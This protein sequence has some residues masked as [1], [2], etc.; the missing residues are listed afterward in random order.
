[1]NDRKVLVSGASLAGPTLAYWLA[2]HGFE[3]TVVERAEKPRTG[4][5]PI[6]VR[7]PA[8]EVAAK[9]GILPEIT[10]ARTNTRGI[11]FVDGT[12]KRV[13]AVGADI[14]AE[15][16]GHDIE[17]EREDLVN[18]LFG[19]AKNDVEYV[20]EE[21]IK[22]LDQDD[23]GVDVTFAQGG[24]RRFDF[25]V[26][27]DGLHSAVRRLAFGEE[28]RFVRHLG[29]YVGIVD[30]DPR[31]ARTD[32]GVM[33]N[34]P[35]KLAGVYSFHGKAAAVFM[36]RSPELSYDYR[37]LDEQKK[38]LTGVFEN[39]SWQVPG[40]LDALATADDFYF[41]SVSQVRMTPWSQGRVSLVGDAG[42]CPALLSGMGTSLAMVGASVLANELAESPDDHARA[43]ARYHE[44]HRPLVDKAQAS[45]ARG[46]GLLIPAT[47][48]AIWR[49]NQLAKVFPLVSAARRVLKPAKSVRG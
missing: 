44:L 3:V 15:Q 12:G 38:L 40:L 30:V 10:A 16:A 20:F 25:V 13:A 41:D 23:G 5:S 31:F 11:E 34:S 29:M 48:G 32:W 49:R 18:I 19:A 1:M 42:Y 36:F 35:G 27:A 14:G 6:D 33:H 26:G 17:L 2:R 22:T 24:E 8:V 37:D 28:S 39:E 46:S 9:M 43:F 21:S 47:K 7:G 45:V 4:G